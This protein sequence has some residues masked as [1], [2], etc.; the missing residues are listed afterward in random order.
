M[1]TMTDERLLD[2][3]H[4]ALV[5]RLFPSIDIDTFGRIGSGWTY[6][7]YDVNGEWIVR[8]PRTAYAME[9]LRAEVALLPELSGEVSALIPVPSLVSTDPPAMVYAKLHGVPADAA[10][11]GIWPER[12]GR[13]L[14]DLHM[15]PPEFVGLRAAPSAAIREDVRARCA[16]L[17]E[18]V[19]P[20]L[21]ASWR[22]RADALL[23]AYVEDDR[24]WTFATCVTHG[25]LGPE[26]VLV[27]EGGDLVGI[28]DWE[29]TAIGDPVWDFAWWLHEMPDEGER[30]L[31]AYGG[32]PDVT[33]RERARF[34]WA[35]M[36]WHEVE[37]GV[38]TGQ[39]AFIDSGLARVRAHLS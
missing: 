31:G 29:E 17:A 16:R 10:P 3:E 26:H 13:F 20:R 11:G 18:M 6:D 4:L 34:G 21:D 30:A 8:F 38:T 5:R 39:D 1:T 33:F 25:D 32:P 2:E 22:Q 24:L 28:L 12:L 35:L 37:Y 7:T 15:V 9:R 36:P 27:G 14:Y 23:S 19:L